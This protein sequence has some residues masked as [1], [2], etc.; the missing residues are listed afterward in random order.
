MSAT[1]RLGNVQAALV[2]QGVKDVKF[3]FAFSP[4]KSTS[5]VANDAAKL[6]GSYVNGACKEVKMFDPKV[7]PS[8]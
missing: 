8:E 7:A 3:F 4:R 5:E 2:Q 6:L 1:S